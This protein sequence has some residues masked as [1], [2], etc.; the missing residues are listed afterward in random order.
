MS[1]IAGTLAMFIRIQLAWPGPKWPLL[2]KLMPSAFPGG[3]MA[4]EFYLQVITM[5]GTLMIFFVISLALI[6]AFGNYP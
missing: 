1:F 3:V 5:H 4:P 2:E 6:G